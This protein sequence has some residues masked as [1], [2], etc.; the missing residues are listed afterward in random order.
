MFYDTIKIFSFDLQ[1]P[2]STPHQTANHPSHPNY[3]FACLS[4]HSRGIPERLHPS[5][6]SRQVLQTVRFAFWVPSILIRFIHPV[7]VP[8]S[9]YFEIP[10]G[11]FYSDGRALAYSLAHTINR[12]QTSRLR[13][14]KT[15][16]NRN[17]RVR[18][19]AREILRRY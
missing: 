18:G 17:H 19:P 8:G 12:F 9:H 16:T 6:L 15:F 5:A 1:W 4:P 2:Q 13:K 14:V 3:T 11:L 10:S 7:P